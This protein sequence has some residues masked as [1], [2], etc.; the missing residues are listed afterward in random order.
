MFYKK[1]I[2][3]LIWPS[4]FAFL[5]VSIVFVNTIFCFI[6][7]TGSE[8]SLT[9]TLALN[10]EVSAKTVLLGGDTV[11]FEYYSRGVLVLGKNKLFTKDSFV[12]NVLDNQLV[13]GDI[14]V[15]V[16]DQ[17]VNT[18][19]DISYI[20]NNQPQDQP[21]NIKAIRKGKEYDTTIRPAYD[22]LTKK[23]KLGLWVKNKINGLGT[24]TYIDP[25]TQKFAAL[26]HS[27]QDVNTGVALNVKEGEIYECNILGIKRGVRGNAG[28][29]RGLLKNG[30][31]LGILEQNLACGI[32]G[33]ITNEEFI[34]NHMP[35]V[36]G[37]KS[38]I[39]PGKA[40]IYC[41]LDGKNIR[42]YDIEIIKTNRQNAGNKDIVLKITD[43]RLLNAAGGIV[44]GM[45]GSPIVQNGKLVGAVTHVFVNDASK[46]F[47]IFIDNMLSN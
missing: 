45:S 44:Q 25:N 46:G 11:G 18:P 33:S 5:C 28:E 15:M 30:T 26:G 29:L 4:I 7:T 2:I 23:Y 32:Y 20:L 31:K 47:G 10:N 42:A 24:L 8:I 14:I 6:A 27:V 35:I 17:E 41:S 43:E 22:L 38:T 40:L 9:G 1:D 12:D 3:N 21:A 39:V 19:E 36:V 37:G 34:Q 16:N 13:Q